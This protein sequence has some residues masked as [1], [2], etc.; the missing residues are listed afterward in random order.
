MYGEVYRCT[1]RPYSGRWKAGND[2]TAAASP[3]ATTAIWG[4][5][6]RGR[7]IGGCGLRGRRGQ[8]RLRVGDL[9]RGWNGRRWQRRRGERGEG[10][11]GADLAGARVGRA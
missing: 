11:G 1:A 2:A 5:R 10:L 9:A 7:P 6:R 4:A 8:G 3:S